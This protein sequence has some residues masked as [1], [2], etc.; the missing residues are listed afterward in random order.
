[1]K[2]GT[3]STYRELGSSRTPVQ[4][5]ATQSLVGMSRS[6]VHTAG[7]LRYIRGVDYSTDIETC[8]GSITVR[9]FPDREHPLRFTAVVPCILRP[10]HVEDGIGEERHHLGWVMSGVSVDWPDSLDGV[11]FDADN[12]LIKRE[13][14]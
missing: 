8:P 13:S 3:R 2:P 6:P 9:D 5:T 11:E 14:L 12:P 7:L 4:R 10:G 1:M